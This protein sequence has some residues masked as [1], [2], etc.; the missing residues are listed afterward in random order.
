[1][2]HR[3]TKVLLGAALF[4]LLGGTATV[5]ARSHS[6]S[7]ARRRTTSAFIYSRTGLLAAYGAEEH[8]GL[9]ARAQVRSPT[10]R[11]RSTARRSTSRYVDDKTDAGHGRHR[12]EGPDRPGLQDHRRHGVARASRC[13]SRRSPRRT[14][15]STSRALRP[16]T[17]SPASTSTRSA[18]AAR[19]C[20][21]VYAADIV[22]ARAPARRSSSSTRT[23][24]SATATTPRSRPCSAARATRSPRS[25]CR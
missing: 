17:R 24:C 9:Q 3:F 5:A 16:P 8:P 6:T 7:A 14:T 23:R 22:P 11:T 25:R 1:M 21:D 12:R 15:S 2:R 18:P 20:Q 10:A 4:M 13:S 19:R